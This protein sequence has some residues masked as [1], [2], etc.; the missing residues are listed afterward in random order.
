M[1]I[2]FGN[3]SKKSAST[4]TTIL[5]PLGD[6]KPPRRKNTIKGSSNDQED[7][8]QPFTIQELNAALETCKGSSPGPD[9]VHY[10]M[11]KNLPITAKY[12]LLFTYNRFWKEKSLTDEW[13]ESQHW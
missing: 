6:A 1:P 7:Y 4:R 3:T 2:S 5:H 9:K 8:N 11:L 10:E 13:T 12:A